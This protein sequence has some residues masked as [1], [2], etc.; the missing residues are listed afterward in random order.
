MARGPARL[1][2]R[3]ALE[4]EADLPRTGVRRVLARSDVQA[5]LDDWG[6][7]SALALTNAAATEAGLALLASAL[8]AAAL[9]GADFGLGVVVAVDAMNRDARDDDEEAVEVTARIDELEER[10]AGSRR[11]GNCSSR[12]ATRS[13][14]S[15][16][17][18][19]GAAR[20]ERCVRRPRCSHA[21]A[22][23]VELDGEVERGRA[24]VPPRR[25]GR[26]AHALRSANV[27]AIR[28]R[29]DRE[30]AERP[31]APTRWKPSCS[32]SA[33][34]P[35]RPPRLRRRRTPSRSDAD[36]GSVGRRGSRAAGASEACPAGARR[37]R[38][39]RR[40]DAARA[41][42][43]LVVDGYNVSKTGW[44]NAVARGRARVA[45]D[46]LHGLHLTSGT[47]VVVVFDGD[48]TQ[49]FSSPAAR[50]CGSCSR[51]PGEEAD[52]VVVEIVSQT[53]LGT[54][55]VVASS[56]RWV[57][58]H[59]ETFGAVVIS[60]AT[61]V[62]VLAEGAGPLRRLIRLDEVL[63]SHRSGR[64]WENRRSGSGS[65][66][67]KGGHRMQIRNVAR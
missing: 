36:G 10:V 60:A 49:S 29:R 59:A 34:R 42:V 50:A 30:R 62:A 40:R 16:A 54:P 48:G 45:P 35:R 24:R 1:Q 2:L 44:P 38:E 56:D 53:P 4:S 63:G 46:A 43:L 3:R 61:L 28:P 9:P 65:R 17:A 12:S 57:R 20:R 51:R 5:A 18:S 33:T 58:E 23:I 66:L 64:V 52:S 13:R 27:A 39:R 22:R 37:Q 55:V 26:A 21:E 7:G 47:D 31:S 25:G 19:A 15:C 8:V 32:G 6:A 14:N 11:R 41:P 67:G